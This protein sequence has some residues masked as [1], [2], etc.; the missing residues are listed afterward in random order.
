MSICPSCGEENPER[1]R[2]CGFCGTP[3]AAESTARETRKV[4]TVVFV[5]L[6]ASTEL[7]DARD[8]E[9]VRELVSRYFDEMRA[10]LESHGGTV[11]KYIGDAV[12]AVF[13]LPTVHEDDAL[14][15]VRAA[16]GMQSALESLND[17]L[18]QRWGVR[19]ANRTGVNT[20]EVISGDASTGQRLAI[21][22]AVNVA[23]RLEQA[24]PPLGILLGES[25]YR[26]VRDAVV[27]EPVEPLELKG[28]PEP[29]PAYSL[30][31]L[32]EQ[33]EHTR[34]DTAPLVGRE[35]ELA[36][37]TVELGR[38]VA[39]R[40]CRVV[41]VVAAA[42]LG[43][44]R[45]TREFARIVEGEARVLFGRCLAYGRGITFWPLVEVVR[46]AC[47]IREED[48]P[49]VALSRLATLE[50]DD[51][52]RERIASAMGLSDL[53]VPVEEVFWAVRKLFEALARERPLVVVFED[54]HWGETTFLDLID[55]VAESVSDAPVLLLCAARPELDE[56][57]PPLGGEA[58]AVHIELQPLSE[59]ESALVVEGLVGSDGLD[60]QV[61]E[62][63]VRSAEG[64]PLF[65]EQLLSMLVDDGLVR[66]EGD[67]W[68]ASGD[69]GELALPPTIQALLA[70]RLDHLSEDE[71]ALIETASVVGYSFGEDALSEVAPDPLGAG[72][73]AL[74]AALV[75]KQFIRAD[76]SRLAGGR[77]F[78][79]NHILIRDAAYNGIL[80]RSRAAL[81][82]RFVVWA[83][84]VN[85]ER[86]RETEYE[87]ILGYHLEQA[88]RYLSE[89]GPL[90]DHGREL[91]MRAGE[92]LSSAGRR[93]FARGDM[94]A[95][96]NLLRRAADLYRADGERRLELLPLLGEAFMEIGEFAWA[97][98]QLDEA[99][100]A[101]ALRDDNGRKADVALTRLLVLHHVTDD[102]DRWRADVV[103][104][105]KLVV[106][107]AERSG[108]HALLAKAWRLL[109]FVHASICHWGD[110]V[111]AV[112]QAI[113]HARL[114]GDARLEARLS[115]GYTTGLCD[116]PTPVSEAIPRCEEILARGLTD[117][118]SEGIVLCSLAYLRALRGDFDRARPLYDRAHRLLHDLGGA[119]LA[120]STSL[121]SARVELLAGDPVSAEAA[122]SRDY[123]ALTAMGERYFRPLVAALLAQA[124]CLQGRDEEATE[125]AGVAEELA[126]EHDV[127][128]Q[129][130]WRRV[131]AL[132]LARQGRLG[133]AEGLVLEALARLEETDALVMHADALVD[134]AQVLF[135]TRPAEGRVAL[136]D[137]LERYER[138]G[139]AVSA[140]RVR[141][142]LSERSREKA[143]E[144]SA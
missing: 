80:K 50:P 134:L 57:R 90:D 59:E 139:N 68:V 49:D 48:T 103:R 41:T 133:E 91:G 105:V 52:V 85:R 93:A 6:K 37:A 58:A 26:L 56:L 51:E 40:S 122:L 97:Q 73:P 63:I 81:H 24:A 25:T 5:D 13:G 127:E 89:L 131:N 130:L 99:V 10:V 95:A 126:D 27:V 30:L 77:T 88:H 140:A 137:A 2:L 53:Q 64:N 111:A 1:F 43:K 39:E 123:D 120:A 129:A 113:V 65:V 74:C 112:E 67:R 79:F 66:R 15:A 70:A 29:V 106:P 144:R 4:V 143:G 114:A 107:E 46:D 21:G 121:D 61:R 101:V 98:L 76:P 47:G 17:E 72:V 119:V 44:S 18:E 7:A 8:P 78:R 35:R 142:L 141:A 110:Q 69:L 54:V 125:I 38:A 23:A 109:G 96:A 16:L 71:R 3:L 32:S 82:E 34:E 117:R 86:H 116:G 124:I 62:R 55:R 14:R 19:L 36:S 92:R 83:E 128:A 118:Q 108:D 45:F 31:A 28:K 75:Q 135:E 11:E 42:G 84:R 136:E 20:G 22:D 138:K 9:A 12:M 33:E 60:P 100:E 87:E 115:A 132:V 104:E 94:P 102:L